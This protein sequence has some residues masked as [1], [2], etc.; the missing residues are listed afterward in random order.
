MVLNKEEGAYMGTELDF[1][2]EVAQ[3]KRLVHGQIMAVYWRATPTRR[4]TIQHLLKTDL[5][6]E[7]IL[8]QALSWDLPDGRPLR[9]RLSRTG[10]WHKRRGLRSLIMNSRGKRLPHLPHT[11][12]VFY[13]N[14]PAR[15]GNHFMDNAEQLEKERI[16]RV[17]ACMAQ[18]LPVSDLDK[19]PFI[20]S[21]QQ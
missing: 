20:V 1:S 18:G 10:R 4:D 7:D 12:P 3:R 19:L 5:A 15:S 8:A 11:L 14:R 13:E 21:W 9:A 17:T 2:P 16:L 6:L